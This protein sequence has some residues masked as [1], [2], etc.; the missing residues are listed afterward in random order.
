[1][2]QCEWGTCVLAKAKPNLIIRC[3]H[4]YAPTVTIIKICRIIYLFFAQ[5]VIAHVANQI[6]DIIAPAYHVG[7]RKKTTI[8]SPMIGR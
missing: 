7:E 5:R 8:H 6:M 4:L 1:M 2:N 3:P